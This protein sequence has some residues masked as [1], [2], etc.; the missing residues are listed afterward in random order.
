MINLRRLF[1]LAAVSTLAL[2]CASTSPGDD[3]ARREAPDEGPSASKA[4]PLGEAACGTNA[5][6]SSS[7]GEIITN[8]VWGCR[9]DESRTSPSTYGSAGCANQ[10]I[11]QIQDTKSV[12]D[13][14]LPFAM[15]ATLPTD[16]V[17][18]AKTWTTVA[19]YGRDSTGWQLRG[20]FKQQGTWLDGYC[21]FAPKP[22]WD[23]GINGGAYDSVRA[24]GS[25][26]RLEVIKGTT[27]TVY[28]PVRTGVGGGNSC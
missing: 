23:K 25:A 9:F 3:E 18:C 4:E 11:V 5:I 28:I 22:V 10:F 15:P 13:P 6:S 20:V 24:V 8:P 12:Q 2:A 1:A 19:G 21:S 17:T 14:L 16:E 26:Y 7:V 27:Y